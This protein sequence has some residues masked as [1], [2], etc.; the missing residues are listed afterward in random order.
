MS[1]KEWN[2]G[3]HEI[4]G[5]PPCICSACAARRRGK[6]AAATELAEY[7]RRL[8]EAQAEL[9]GGHKPLILPDTP[10]YGVAGPSLSSGY[11]PEEWQRV[12]ETAPGVWRPDPAGTHIMH[13]H[14][15][16]GGGKYLRGAPHA[17]RDQDDAPAP[18]VRIPA[19]PLPDCTC[20]HPQSHQWS[21]HTPE[22]PARK[23]L[24]ELLWANAAAA[25]EAGRGKQE[26]AGPEPE[27]DPVDAWWEV[28]RSIRGL[29]CAQLAARYPDQPPGM[30]AICRLVPVVPGRAWCE[31]CIELAD[32]ADAPARARTGTP[33]LTEGKSHPVPVLGLMIGLGLALIA[34]AV[35]GATPLIIPGVVLLGCSVALIMK[36]GRP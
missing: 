35:T 27:P 21:W 32:S 3:P 10:V 23:R 36:R 12:T 29:T 7:R 31:D 14:P 25:H 13:A 17:L 8:S 11:P 2:G 16:S 18:V 15:V 4:P 6:A 34:L 20:G 26:A 22:C 24:V 1:E 33:V 5:L 30:C 28:M 19:G 9:D